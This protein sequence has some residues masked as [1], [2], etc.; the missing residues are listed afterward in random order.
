MTTEEHVVNQGKDLDFD[1]EF[2]PDLTVIMLGYDRG[3]IFRDFA[4]KMMDCGARIHSTLK[5]CLWAPII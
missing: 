4:A 3:Y 5:R 2:E 1:P